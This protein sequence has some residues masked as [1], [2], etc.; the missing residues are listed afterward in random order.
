MFF[1]THQERKALL[2]IA[3]LILIGAV[4]KFSDLTAKDSK[5]LPVVVVENKDKKILVNI[6]TADR[7]EL[8]NVPGIGPTTAQRIIEYRSSY[9]FFADLED[10]EKVKGIGPKKSQRM[11]EY[12]I[13]CE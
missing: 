2:S 3:V 12:I 1:L 11:K 9:G 4:L 13:F 7:G 6:N 5:N 10:L 8:T